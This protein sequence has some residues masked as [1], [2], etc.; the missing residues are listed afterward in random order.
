MKLQDAMNREGWLS[1][2]ETQALAELE[3][4]IDDI[5]CAIRAARTIVE[6]R[7]RVEELEQQAERLANAL[8]VFAHDDLCRDVGGSA[9]G[10]D[11]VVF[12]R[13]NALLTLGDFRAAR[14]AFKNYREGK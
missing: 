5:D 7:D 8:E 14:F 11:S 1:A 12:G 13:D 6:L 3:D 10:A 4:S 9:W 2:S